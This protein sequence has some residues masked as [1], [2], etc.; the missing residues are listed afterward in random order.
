MVNLTPCHPPRPLYQPE[1]GS[2]GLMPSGHSV[3]VLP[4]PTSAP[5]QRT[6]QCIH[7]SGFSQAGPPPAKNSSVPCPPPL[8]L[9]LP[10]LPSAPAHRAG[11]PQSILPLWP[12]PF[13]GDQSRSEPECGRR[14][15]QP[16]R[17]VLLAAS[18][19]DSVAP[20]PP[21]PA[22][23]VSPSI[24]DFRGPHVPLQRHSPAG[25]R[26]EEVTVQRWL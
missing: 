2:W 15:P 13:W 11:V 8:P 19:G 26:E 3:S 24:R 6:P 4:L 17:Y 18:P 7:F 20:Q 21:S 14:P 1:G 10:P 16:F 5:A 22:L 25:L 23:P 9:P 12:S